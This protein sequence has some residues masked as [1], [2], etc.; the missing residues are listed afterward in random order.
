VREKI[1]VDDELIFGEFEN[2]EDFKIKKKEK[3]FE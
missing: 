3:D 1:D 2:W